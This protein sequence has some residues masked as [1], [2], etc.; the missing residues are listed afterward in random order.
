MNAA[1]GDD[2]LCLHVDAGLTCALVVAHGFAA[3]LVLVLSYASPWIAGLLLLLVM[4]N[5]TCRLYLA[6]RRSGWR[7][8]HE[9]GVWV[10]EKPVGGSGTGF[11]EQTEFG[12]CCE[13]P[14]VTSWLV[15]ITLRGQQL[16]KPQTFAFVPAATSGEGWRRLHALIKGDRQ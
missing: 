15:T 12:V 6:K 11:G 5:L 2:D 13:F 9:N 10:L 7:L 4:A 16:P 3:L 1:E 14:Y 8:C